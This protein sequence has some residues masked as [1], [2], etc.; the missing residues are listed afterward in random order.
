NQYPAISVL[1]RYYLYLYKDSIFG[2]IPLQVFIPPNYNNTVASPLVLLLHGAVVMSSFKD[3]YKD[4][5]TDEDIFLSYFQKNDFVIVRP[6]ADSKGP[7]TDGTKL[8]D[9]V[10]NDFN[11]IKNKNKTNPTFSALAT[12]VSRLKEVLNIDDNK[13]FAFGHSD[14]ADGVFA[15]QVYRPSLFAGF[16]V[17]NSMLTNL[18]AYDIYLR[19]TQNRPLYLIHSDLDDLRPIQQARDIVKILDS[20]KSPFLYKEYIGYKHFDKHLQID[21]PYCYAWTKQIS[22]NPF[23][24]SLVWEMSDVTNNTCDWLKIID[25]D[26][27]LSQ[28]ARWHTELN[29]PL[30]NKRDGKYYGS[31]YQLNKSGAVMALYNNNKFE[32]TTS[33]VNEVELLIS[34]IMVNLQNPV[35]VTI[36]G[37]VV[38]DN[39]VTAQKDFLLNTFSNS[40]D[41]RAL[42]VTS[43]KLKIK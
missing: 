17:Y 19:N 26:T 34:P 18:F 29:A 21:I 11:G 43:I 27:G 12:I 8:F 9:W 36:N 28:P 37:K 14:G 15:L 32:I 40:F 31:Y 35:I 24:K 4:T 5:T 10:M 25:I 30:Y 33:R 3:A 41:R 16:M 39:K 1:N 13:V 6:F 22:R 2:D 20:L 42:W 7:N 23:Q 38:F